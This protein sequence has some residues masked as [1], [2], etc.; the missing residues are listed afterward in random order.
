[1]WTIHV[2]AARKFLDNVSKNATSDFFNSNHYTVELVVSVQFHFVYLIDFVTQCWTEWAWLT[3]LSFES[4]LNR[5]YSYDVDSGFLGQLN[6]YT[7]SEYNKFGVFI[8]W[9]QILYLFHTYIKLGEKFITE[10]TIIYMFGN[11]L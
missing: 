10:S 7:I 9:L 6:D 3:T 8:V 11:I 1:M 2:V 4:S 5:F